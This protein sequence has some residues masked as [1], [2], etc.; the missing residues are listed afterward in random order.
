MSVHTKE[1]KNWNAYLDLYPN[2]IDFQSIS[3]RSVLEN[4]E[5][6]GD[7]LSIAREVFHW[8]YFKNEIERKKYSDKV[9]KENFEVVEETYDQ[10]IELP[11]GLKIKRLDH[12]DYNHID[13]YTLY[14]WQ[15]AKNHNADYD[16]WE[17]SVEKD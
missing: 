12:V 4:L 2:E 1:D 6:N 15:L 11:F 16:G 9:R 10:N 14:L 8:I 17:T 3:N 5:R 13:E 7:N